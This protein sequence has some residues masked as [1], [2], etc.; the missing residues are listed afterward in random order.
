M[1]IKGTFSKL[2]NPLNY[3]SKINHLEYPIFQGRRMIDDVQ[4]HEV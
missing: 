2:N 3:I 4:S 1:Y